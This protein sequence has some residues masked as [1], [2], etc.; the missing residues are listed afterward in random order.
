MS[1]A[2]E[3][4]VLVIGAGPAGCCA[5]ERAA[6]A[7][8]RVLLVD[9]RRQIGLPVQCAEFVPWQLGQHVPIPGRC[10]A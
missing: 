7:G 5:A 3:C 10:I 6:A 8:A 9:K 2:E 1:R 4:D